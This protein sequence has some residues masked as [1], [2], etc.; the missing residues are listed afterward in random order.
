VKIIILC[1]YR[2]QHENCNGSFPK[3]IIFRESRKGVGSKNLSRSDQEKQNKEKKKKRKKKKEKRKKE[4]RKRLGDQKMMKEID[5][6]CL[7][8]CNQQGFKLFLCVSIF[9]YLS[10]FMGLSFSTL[11]FF[12]Y[13]YVYPFYFTF[14]VPTYLS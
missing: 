1:L 12:L 9:L 3:I 14:N 8:V 2:P 11:F 6:R 5:R 4:K 13:P 10:E 7:L